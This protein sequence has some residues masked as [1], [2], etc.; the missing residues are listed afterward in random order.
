MNLG[1]K[2]SL[3]E[4]GLQLDCNQYPRV[5]NFGVV[6]PGDSEIGHSIPGED[7]AH[8][9]ERQKQ[10]ETGSR[11]RASRR[12]GAPERSRSTGK[13]TQF[14]CSSLRSKYEAELGELREA[15]PGTQVWMQ[16]EGMWLLTESTVLPG[17]GKKAT[18]LTAVPFSIS[19]IQQSWGFWTT[20]IYTNW[21]GP[22]HTNFPDGS[23]CAFDPK[24]GTWRLGDKLCDLI[25]LY[26]VWALRQEH[27]NVFGRWPGRQSVPHSYERVTESRPNELCGCDTQGLYYVDCCHNRDLSQPLIDHL[28]N[29][30]AFTHWQIERIPPK[31][32]VQ[33]V[34][35][36]VPPSTISKYLIPVF[37]QIHKDIAK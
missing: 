35:N 2:N 23:I 14:L 34:Q 27:L 18:F 30:L 4:V 24:D 13:A 37:P 15:Y 8:E 26:T 11:K 19:H 6:K 32:I 21:I 25:D 31:E 1:E 29:F 36:R 22:R 33:A 9:Y 5:Y 12:Q 17:L 7:L 3:R 10:S 28:F 20:P 16:K